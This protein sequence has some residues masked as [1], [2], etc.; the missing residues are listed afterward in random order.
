MS[1]NLG[2]QY[3]QALY[4]GSSSNKVQ[5][6]RKKR[7]IRLHTLAVFQNTRFYYSKLKKIAPE[8]SFLTCSEDNLLTQTDFPRNFKQDRRRFKS[9]VDRQMARKY[10]YIY[11]YIRPL[12]RKNEVAPC[13]WISRA[14]MPRFRQ[15][16][17]A[18]G[19]PLFVFHIDTDTDHDE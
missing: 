12:K 9:K 10:I 14:E 11:I 3:N 16:A 18:P 2:K 6:K 15:D 4:L 7:G 1:Q 8:I 19:G 5:K 13:I 17:T